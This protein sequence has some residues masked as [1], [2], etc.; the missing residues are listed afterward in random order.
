MSCIGSL[1]IIAEQGGTCHH[2]WMLASVSYDL[3][4]PLSV[5]KQESDFLA[6]VRLV[7]SPCEPVAPTSQT[8][9]MTHECDEFIMDR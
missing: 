2:F 8:A 7:Q 6:D 4:Q 1:G 5:M 3:S 9:A